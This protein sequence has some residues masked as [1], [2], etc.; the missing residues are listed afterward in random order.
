[1]QKNA[2]ALIVF[3]FLCFFKNDLTLSGARTDELVNMI[4]YKITK[5]LIWKDF[6]L[7]FGNK[8]SLII[9]LDQIIF[10]IKQMFKHC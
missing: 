9:L 8:Y 7:S 6:Q 10:D 3:S 4:F 5:T 2:H 1:M